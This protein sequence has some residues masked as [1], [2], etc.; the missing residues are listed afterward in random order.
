MVNGIWVS[1][2]DLQICYLGA[3]MQ[4]VITIHFLCEKLGEMHI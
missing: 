1:D 4:T 2:I 3:E